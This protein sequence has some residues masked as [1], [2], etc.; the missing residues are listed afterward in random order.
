MSLMPGA[1]NA[2][3][4]PRKLKYLVTSGKAR[5]FTD[6]G[7]HPNREMEWIAA[8]RWHPQLNHIENVYQTVHGVKYTVRCSL[9]SPDG[10]NPCAFTVWMVD[11]GQSVPRFVTGYASPPR[12]NVPLS[13]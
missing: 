2:Q 8:L 4:D 13:P 12:N 7:F 9:P 1:Q 6:H 5:F 3:V 10:R 11:A